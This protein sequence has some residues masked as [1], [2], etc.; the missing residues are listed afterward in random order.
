MKKEQL[1][2]NS[3]YTGMYRIFFIKEAKKLYFFIIWRHEIIKKSLKE[4]I[5]KLLL[6][7]RKVKYC[8]P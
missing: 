7:S 3:M 8:F 1:L 4:L 6:T 2:C 5:V